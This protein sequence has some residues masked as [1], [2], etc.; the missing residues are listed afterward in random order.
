MCAFN[1][2]KTKVTI[3][4]LASVPFIDFLLCVCKFL[5]IHTIS[6]NS[7]PIINSKNTIPPI[8]PPT[9]APSA[10]ESLVRAKERA[11]KY[12]YCIQYPKMHAFCATIIQCIH[13]TDSNYAFTYNLYIQI[14]S[15]SITALPV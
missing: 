6:S 3:H 4:H 1:I 8:V 11:C 10:E 15:Y 14:F 13:I 5:L 2:N 9:V 7:T 12:S